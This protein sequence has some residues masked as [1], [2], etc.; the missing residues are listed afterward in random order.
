MPT[1]DAHEMH[2]QQN[3]RRTLHRPRDRQAHQ[4]K[5]WSETWLLCSA[6]N[7]EQHV[8]G[9]QRVMQAQQTYKHL[10]AGERRI[11]PAGLR[12]PQLFYPRCPHTTQACSWRAHGLRCLDKLHVAF[13]SS[14][15]IVC[16]VCATGYIA[17]VVRTAAAR[18]S[19][20]PLLSGVTIP[21]YGRYTTGP[22]PVNNCE[23]Q[24]SSGVAAISLVFLCGILRWCNP[25]I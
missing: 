24:G 5:S 8:H 20:R 23:G 21:C 3:G 9:L 25:P 11:P 18:A 13:S 15:R 6:R 7:L 16:T 17:S 22:L 4:Q 19:I 14:E 12:R 10:G 2:T 1:N